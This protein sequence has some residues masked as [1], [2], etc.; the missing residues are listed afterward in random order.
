MPIIRGCHL[1][2]QRSKKSN[3]K[4]W[5][6][7]NNN[8]EGGRRSQGLDQGPDSDSKGR[9]NA[10]RN[11]AWQEATRRR[12]RERDLDKENGRAFP[13]RTQQEIDQGSQKGEDGC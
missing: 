7:R 10:V 3:F 1:L 5:T 6:S 4:C 9:A 8:H 13:R 12:G 2:T 11:R